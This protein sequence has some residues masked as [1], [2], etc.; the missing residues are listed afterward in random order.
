MSKTKLGLAGIGLALVLFFALNIAANA[1]LRGI[2]MDLTEDRLFTLDEGSK[3]VARAIDEPIQ[4]NYYFS[5]KV[6]S[7]VPPVVSYADRVL[8]ML[9]EFERESDGKIRLSVIDP[10]PFS[11]E[12]EQAVA[13]GVQGMQIEAGGDPLYFGLVGTSSMDARETIPFFALEEGKQRTLE[14]DLAKLIWTL[15]HP[16]KRKVG[17][18]SALSLEGGGGM[19]MMGQQPEPRWK[20]LDH[21][22]VEV[23]PPTSDE[24]PDDLDAL[25][26]V[27]PRGFQDSTLYLID[28]WALSGKP[29]LVFVD[30]QCE[31]DPGESDP[32]NPMSRY[33]AERGSNLD[34]LF[35]AWGIEMVSGKVV[36]DR[37]NGLRLPVQVRGTN[38]EIEM[39][40]VY[41]M[42]LGPENV[43]KDDP[44]SR[45]L[46]N[47]LIASP[48]ALRKLSDGTTTFKPLLQTS[49]ESM[50]IDATKLQFPDPQEILASFVP[51]YE[52]L[53][54]VARVTGDVKTAFP[55]GKPRA[56]EDG[57]PDAPADD[58]ASAPGLTAS[59]QPLNAVVFSDADLLHDRMWLRELR[60]GNQVL[61]SVFTSHN[62]ELVRNSI[63]SV[64]GGQELMQIHTR[65]RTSRPFER[66]QEIQRDADQRYLAEQQ[67]F[68]R[69]LKD[70]NQRLNELQSARGEGSEELVTAEQR[71]EEDQL[72]LEIVSTKRNLR[73]VEHERRKDIERLGTHIDLL[74]IGLMPLLVSAAAI[75]LGAWKARQR[76]KQ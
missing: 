45:L 48:G 27:Q 19:P 41:Y 62:L 26:V 6:A 65:G 52:K 10:E 64:T 50:L 69:K 13:Q 76:T 60:I 28:Q 51:G 75:A 9:E 21:F 14:F 24:L 42:K 7:D 20:L 16:D 54:L 12:E 2:R 35:K 31:V 74:N 25:M 39:P 55:E 46:E 17:I 71:K 40:V 1:T 63:E 8:G 30:P 22:E 66:V 38:R 58:A 36:G 3:A 73:D 47:V 44:I 32:S 61:G 23:V 29:L 59:A 49:E 56:P 43:D 5:R 15:A 67:E 11:E 68:E 37:A 34:K 53:A 57:N 33:M 72:R 4:L 18:L 70:A